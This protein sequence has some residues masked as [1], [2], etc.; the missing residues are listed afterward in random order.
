MSKVEKMIV[1]NVAG[2]HIVF[3]ENVDAYKLYL[4]KVKNNLLSDFDSSLS[5]IVNGNACVEY[6]KSDNDNVGINI[7]IKT[8][9]K[10]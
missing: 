5:F 9:D 10:L 8:I 4:N 6:Y 3:E 7:K 1:D 2:I